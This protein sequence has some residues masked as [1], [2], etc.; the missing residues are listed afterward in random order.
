MVI[1]EVS[2]MEVLYDIPCRR[3]EQIIG[4][5]KSDQFPARLVDDIENEQSSETP[6]EE[7]IKKGTEADDGFRKRKHVRSE[8]SSNYPIQ[9][10]H[11]DRWHALIVILLIHSTLS[12]ASGQVIDRK[13]GIVNN[14]TG[15][16][17][18]VDVKSEVN[19][20]WTTLET[21]P[22]MDAIIDGKLIANYDLRHRDY[23]LYNNNDSNLYAPFMF[24]NKTCQLTI[25]KVERHVRKVMFI[26]S[27]I[28][29]FEVSG[30]RAAICRDFSSGWIYL[31]ATV[32]TTNMNSSET[33][34]HKANLEIM[35]F[36][37]VG[38]ILFVSPFVAAAIQRGLNRKRTAGVNGDDNH[39]RE[40]DRCLPDGP[41]DAAPAGVNGD[42]NPPR[43]NDRCLPDGT[44]D[45]APAGINGDDNHP[46]ENDRC[47]PDGPIDAAPAGV[48]GDDNPPRENDICLPDGPIDETRQRK[49]ACLV[50]IFEKNDTE[51][52]PENECSG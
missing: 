41:I 39:P 15:C 33:S 1:I 27:D 38:S 19:L 35:I 12:P 11:G 18:E 50:Q 20:R 28:D 34:P 44:I 29:S 24:E 6:N 21:N 4:V 14:V 32:N 37:I 9:S 26:G 13:T 2:K 31:K 52:C 7:T 47:L 25:K 40:N 49:V 46:R 5:G 23:H 36:V 22:L 17:V 10:R 16:L 3:K 30:K 8:H 43:E 45:A 42:D 48:N 51:S